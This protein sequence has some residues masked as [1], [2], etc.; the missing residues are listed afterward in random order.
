[1][2]ECLQKALRIAGTCID[3]ATQLQIYSESLEQFLYYFDQSVPSVRRPWSLRVE[4]SLT[5]AHSLY[6]NTSARS[7]RS[8]RNSWIRY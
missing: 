4:V 5:I 8:P 1:M 2:L 7:S 3:E 6:R